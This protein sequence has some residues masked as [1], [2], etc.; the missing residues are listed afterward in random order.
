[1]IKNIRITNPAN[2]SIILELN[3]PE[4]SGLL[5]KNVDGLGPPSADINVTD[6]ASYDGSIFNSSRITSRQITMNLKF[7]SNELIEDV[8]L[9]TYRYFPQKR[10]I[11]FEIETDRRKCRT[12]G[13]VESNEPNIFSEDEG[14]QIVIN[15]PDAYFRSQTPIKVKFRSVDPEF[16]FPFSNNLPYNK[17]IKM[18]T[19]NPNYAKE[20][21]YDGESETGIIIHVIVLGVVRG[22]S[23]YNASDSDAA[24][25]LDD[26]I[27]ER[28]TG[29]KLL[30]GDEIII[31]TIQG[32]RSMKLVRQA[33]T[34]NILN[35]FKR[36]IDWM[37]ITYGNN[38]FGYNAIEGVEYLDFNIEYDILYTGV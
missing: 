30:I 8:R 23:I 12:E 28:L 20:L 19:I 22:L 7:L 3:R 16:K 31:S 13:Y 26:D 36:P 29:S 35:A 4:L 5:I 2:E 11:L 9:L 17:L 21:F 6:L 25:S 38:Y 10:K 27:L 14:C 24:M 1:M 33:V 15:C 37:T 18:G 34:Y 32:K